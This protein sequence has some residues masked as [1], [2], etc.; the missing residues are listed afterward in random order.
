MK[1]TFLTFVSLLLV[2]CSTSKK[3]ADVPNVELSLWTFKTDSAICSTPQILG[4]HIY[5]GSNDDSFYCL[6][7]LTG[8]LKWE[9]K[10]GGPVSSSCAFHDGIVFFT[11]SDCN[12]YAI[13]CE[14]GKKVW[15]HQTKLATGS[16]PL[17]CGDKLIIIDRN[18]SLLGLKANS[19]K[20]LWKFDMPFPVGI[21]EI[22][23]KVV[24]VTG[25]D[26]FLYT[27]NA[28][29]G[30]ELWKYN[31][32]ADNSRKPLVCD[33]TIFWPDE[34][35]VVH[36]VN[37]NGNLLWK[38]K[39][40]ERGLTS[41]VSNKDTIV[42]GCSSNAVIS[43]GKKTG[44]QVWIFPT[45]SEVMYAPMIYKDS[46]FCG[47]GDG[48]I[49]SIN[50]TN[51]KTGLQNKQIKLSDAV[52]SVPQIHNDVLYCGTIDGTMHAIDLKSWMTPT[53]QK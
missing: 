46:V 52:Y 22:G 5:F 2:A 53:K 24:Y 30:K 35:D 16:T 27:V 32:N 17:I 13:S 6:N 49:Y 31:V 37:K 51:L 9:F 3:Q 47:D 43:L 18:S 34:N 40:N 42:F 23:D 48:N 4:D 1:K 33:Q 19:G 36:A 21:P 41:C 26:N 29:T 11:S 25:G 38:Q 8:K 14:T 39:I 50:A 20:L 28:T 12:T 10:T 7:K 15:S 45:Y 44:D